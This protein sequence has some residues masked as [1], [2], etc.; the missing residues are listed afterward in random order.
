MREFISLP[1]VSLPPSLPPSLSLPLPPSLSLSPSHS[2]SLSL[3]LPLTLSAS[4]SLCLSLTASPSLCLSLSLRVMA[5]VVENTFTA[6][7]SMAQLMFPGASHFPL[8]CF[9]NKVYTCTCTYITMYSANFLS[10]NFRE[11]L[12]INVANLQSER[13]A[14]RNLVKFH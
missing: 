11:L 14:C 4:H 6:I 10:L 7:P 12:F 5:L 13:R 2:L 3:S 1:S 9:K 8:F